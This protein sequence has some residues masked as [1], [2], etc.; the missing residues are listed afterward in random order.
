MNYR[1]LEIGNLNQVPV[2]FRRSIKRSFIQPRSTGLIGILKIV[3]MALYIFL[4]NVKEKLLNTVE[5]TL[6]YTDVKGSLIRWV[7]T[8]ITTI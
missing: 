6:T 1:K 5:Y 2:S 7:Q 8:K 3:R 4:T